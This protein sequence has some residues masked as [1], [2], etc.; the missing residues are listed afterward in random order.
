MIRRYASAG[1]VVTAGD[2][3][4]PDFLLLDQ[5]RRTGERQTVA[6]KGR[7]EPDEAPLRAARREVAEE[8]GLTDTHYSAYL[9]QEAY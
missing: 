8:A 9:G 2:L 7:L 1:A 5:V 6:P 3:R 4:K